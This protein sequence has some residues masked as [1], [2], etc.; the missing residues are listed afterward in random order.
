MYVAS[1]SD[2][3][4]EPVLMSC[5]D[6]LRL[7]PV[8]SRLQFYFYVVSSPMCHVLVH[9]V[10]FRRGAVYSRMQCVVS[11]TAHDA[12]VFDPAM[13]KDKSVIWNSAINEQG[14]IG[15]ICRGNPLL[16]SAQVIA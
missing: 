4:F 12:A 14:D 9:V 15:D 2:S 8:S 16:G 1:P 7:I 6:V 3:T 10:F 5:D 13:K 11:I